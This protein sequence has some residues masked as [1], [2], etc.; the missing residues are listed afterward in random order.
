MALQ[1]RIRSKYLGRHELSP[2][3]SRRFHFGLDN[4][5]VEC[6]THG[7]GTGFFLDKLRLQH[8]AR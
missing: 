5:S 6:S 7:I 8:H 4:N 1:D 2:K 3:Y